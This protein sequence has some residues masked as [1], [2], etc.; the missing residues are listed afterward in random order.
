MNKIQKCYVTYIDEDFDCD[1]FFPID[2]KTSG[3]WKEIECND[4]YDTNYECTVSYLVYERC[5]S[6]II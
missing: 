1:T 3:E 6:S 4:T 5:I 2:F